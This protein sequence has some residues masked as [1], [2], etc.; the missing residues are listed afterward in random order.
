MGRAGSAAATRFVFAN[1]T[2]IAG[3]GPHN[4]DDI[5][6]MS[7]DRADDAHRPGTRRTKLPQDAAN[8]DTSRA[9]PVAATPR[10]KAAQPPRVDVDVARERTAI[11]SELD[12]PFSV[13]RPAEITTPFVFCSPHSGNIYPSVFL[14]RSQLKPNQLRKSE[15]CFVDELF[16]SAV[17]HGAP[18]IAAHFPRAYLDVNREPY[19]LDPDL[20]EGPLPDFANTRTM[21]VI[22]GLGTIARVVSETEQIY[23]APLPLATAYERIERLYRPFHAGITELMDEVAD[24]FGY[25]VLVDCHSMPSGMVQSGTSRPDFV[26]G[27]RFGSSCDARVTRVVRQ[28]LAQLGYRV[29]LN[30]PY[31]GGFIT[32]HYGRPYQARHAVQIEINRGLYLDEAAYAKSVGFTHL[33]RHLHTFIGALT[34]QIPGLLQ[35]QVAAE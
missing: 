9:R 20:F 3:R 34:V 12:P 23:P 22:G 15:D 11:V 7:S 29:Q 26:I 19:E 33:Q 2:A 24:R 28:Q 27:D 32:E 4:N 6:H 17:D 25:A 31:A 10:A 14:S 5:G 30:R 8:D 13:F 35:G 1:A 18:L 21:R 16:A